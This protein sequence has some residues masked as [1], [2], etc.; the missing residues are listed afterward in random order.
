MNDSSK[1]NTFRMID[2]ETFS[3][4]IEDGVYMVLGSLVEAS[5]RLNNNYDVLINMNN[6]DM[7]ISAK[8][9][10]D[11]YFA[12]IKSSPDDE[13]I[14]RI[15]YSS[16]PVV[17]V[18]NKGEFRRTTIELQKTIAVYR[19]DIISREIVTNLGHGKKFNLEIDVQPF[20]RTD[21]KV[22]NYNDVRL[23]TVME[24]IAI[25]EELIAIQKWGSD[26]GFYNSIYKI[27]IFK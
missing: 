20:N 24:K 18:T 7:L 2:N 13:G 3:V 14:V 26:T 11:S 16:E 25:N 5:D 12:N 4:E 9:N 15:P 23:A 22:T 8:F 21:R 1:T 10:N 19:A 27:T 6:N 17:I